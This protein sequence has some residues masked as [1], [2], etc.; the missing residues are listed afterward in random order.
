MLAASRHQQDTL[1]WN[2]FLFRKIIFLI[3]SIMSII[4]IEY[5]G[6][7][8]PI[9]HLGDSMHPFLLGNGEGACAVT[10]RSGMA[11]TPLVVV[12]PVMGPI[13]APPPD[14]AE[15]IYRLA[16]E[17]ARVALLSSAYDRVGRVSCN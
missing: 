13:A 7:T 14:V 9:G 5:R 3:I 1:V 11:S 2:P 8:H 10:V 17:W 15:Y 16:L 6:F 12:W 4:M